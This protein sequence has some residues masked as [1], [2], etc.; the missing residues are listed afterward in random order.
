[1]STMT[2]TWTKVNGEWCVRLTDCPYPGG[3]GK[4]L[5]VWVETRNGSKKQ[6]VLAERLRVWRVKG[7]RFVEIYR[8]KN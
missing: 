6:V 8:C 7:G 2:A 4:G 5:P 1:M 3:S